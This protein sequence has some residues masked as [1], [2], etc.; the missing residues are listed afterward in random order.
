MF[1]ALINFLN[2]AKTFEF[3]DK[4]TINLHTERQSPYGERNTDALAQGDILHPSCATFGRDDLFLRHVYDRKPPRTQIPYF[5][6][7]PPALDEGDQEHLR[8][9]P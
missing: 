1:F 6:D 9:L 5:A 8:F 4:Q 2:C 3:F 7:F